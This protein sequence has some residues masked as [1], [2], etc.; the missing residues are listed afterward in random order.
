[1]A[2]IEYTN[3]PGGYMLKVPTP[4]IGAPTSGVPGMDF[5]GLTNFYQ[6]MAERRAQEEARRRDEENR[7]QRFQ[8]KM[9][10]SGFNMNAEETRARM[11]AMQEQRAQQAE[12][13]QR[14][15]ALEDTPATIVETG[16]AGAAGLGNTIGMPWQK[17]AGN[18]GYTMS[19]IKQMQPENA[20]FTPGAG[21]PSMLQQQNAERQASDD[22]LEQ[23]KKRMGAMMSL[24]NAWS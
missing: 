2:D 15:K 17:G 13:W 14:K 8:E 10:A 21:E 3:S 9:Q 19:Q 22:A 12:A 23:H 11:E 18:S 20:T 16:Y 4:S 5:S 24:Q 6:Q 7:R 1:M